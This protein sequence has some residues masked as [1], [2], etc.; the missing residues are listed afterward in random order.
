MDLHGCERRLG[1][2]LS[3]LLVL[4]VVSLAVAIA[5][6]FIVLAS[7]SAAQAPQPSPNGYVGSETCAGCHEASVGPFSHTTHAKVLNEKNGRTSLETR[8]CEA[9]HG[10]GEAHVEAGGGRG[11]GDMI[12]F[13]R[14]TSQA[15]GREDAQCLACHQKGQ[16]IHWTA[17]AHDTPTNG[18]TSCHTVMT[19]VS[20][21]ALLSRPT[22]LETCQTCHLVQAG[23][24]WRN[25]HMPLREG[26]MACS[27]CHAPHG[28]PTRPL[29]QGVSVNDTCYGCH[30][31]KRGP[32]LWEHAP[33]V[34]SCMNCHDPHGSLRDNM[35]K[36]AA[37][38]LCQACHIE[39]R[40]PTEARQPTNKFVIGRACQNC[41]QQI[42]GSNHPSGFAF[43]R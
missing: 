12:T 2:A 27:S 8:G 23:K 9:C 1:Y 32:F 14:E 33:V 11:V 6:Q 20:D 15:A 36:V 7:R 28:S 10:P 26:K 13:R 17:S 34:E 16:R 5:A 4:I 30:A 25:G 43:T 40:H 39:T 29:L 22:Q 24:Q 42:H 41:H 35:L 38:R 21:R 31:E 37:P 3:R 18:C 19:K